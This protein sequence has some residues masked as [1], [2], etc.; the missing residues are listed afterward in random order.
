MAF[1]PQQ[2]FSPFGSGQ[3]RIGQKVDSPLARAAKLSLAG[4]AVRVSVAAL[5]DVVGLEGD[6]GLDGGRLAARLGADVEV[7]VVEESLRAGAGDVVDSRSETWND[8][9]FFFKFEFDSK[10]HIF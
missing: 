4:E 8:E 10:T 7:G 6:R 5:S 3:L 1:V 2:I 9:N